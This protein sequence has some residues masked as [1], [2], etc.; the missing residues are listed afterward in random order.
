MKK[1]SYWL[2]AIVGLQVAWMTATAIQKEIHLSGDN[3]VLLETAPVDPR[4]LLRGDYVILRYKI[5]D[6]PNSLFASSLP[7]PPPGGSLGST[8]GGRAV[9]VVLQPNGKFYEALSA[10]FEPPKLEPGQKLIRGTVS[11]EQWRWRANSVQIIYG[12]EKYFVPEGTGNRIGKLTVKAALASD[13]TPI[14]QQVFLDG[15]PYKTP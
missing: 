5:S 14:I 8:L 3:T 4:D 7:Q 15:K 6:I 2:A 10:D 11:N 1:T 13:G 12:I 9:Y